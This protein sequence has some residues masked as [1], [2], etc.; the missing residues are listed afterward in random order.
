LVHAG[1]AVGAGLHRANR[2]IG[3]PLWAVL[4]CMLL[5]LACSA[6]HLGSLRN[7]WR[8]CAN[9]RSSWLSREILFALLFSLG[10]LVLLLL[11]DAGPVLT[12]LRSGLAWMNV[13]FS[14]SLLWSMA[15]IYRLR[16]V[17]DWNSRAITPSFFVSAAVLGGLGVGAMLSFAAETPRMLWLTAMQFVTL[18]AATSIMLQLVL[19]SLRLGPRSRQGRASGPRAPAPGGQEPEWI[20][21][22]RVLLLMGAAALLAGISRLLPDSP[23]CRGALLAAFLMGLVS[24]VLGRQRFY[25]ARIPELP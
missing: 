2:L 12:A 20:Q 1:A 5:A 9:L 16:T 13:F 3:T 17:P 11:P 25:E 7:A 6:W 10:T 24:E 23:M 19:V 21:A 8:A 4:L 15:R 18:F 14:V 22:L